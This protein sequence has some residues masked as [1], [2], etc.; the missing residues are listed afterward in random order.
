MESMRETARKMVVIGKA[1]MAEIDKKDTVSE[2]ERREAQEAFDR[3][4]EAFQEMPKPP[5][6]SVRKLTVKQIEPFPVIGM[7]HLGADGNWVDDPEYSDPKLAS[8][9]IV[10]L[11]RQDEAKV[12][13]FLESAKGIARQIFSTN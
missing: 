2:A 10:G 5:I 12:E 6:V 4:M 8:H 7:A 9:T 1:A 11:Y 13:K 3:I